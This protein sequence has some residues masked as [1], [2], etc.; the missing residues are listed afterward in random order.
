MLA[1]SERNWGVPFDI[2]GEMT[3]I[4]IMARADDVAIIVDVDASECLMGLVYEMPCQKMIKGR[5]YIGGRAMSKSISRCRN[6]GKA[7]GVS[8]EEAAGSRRDVKSMSNEIY[9]NKYDA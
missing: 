9:Q 8:A 3:E 7:I 4:F 2:F 1:V 6:S 5:E